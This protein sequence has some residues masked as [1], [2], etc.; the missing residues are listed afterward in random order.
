LP[1]KSIFLRH[2]YSRK[3][4]KSGTKVAQNDV[5]NKLLTP[6]I[7]NILKIYKKIE[8]WHKS[9]TKSFSKFYGQNKKKKRIC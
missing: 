8:K 3:W 5:F 4:H 1:K 2:F 7:E 9:G 6:Q